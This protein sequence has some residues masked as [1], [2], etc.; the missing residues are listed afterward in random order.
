MIWFYLWIIATAIAIICGACIGWSILERIGCA[1]GIGFLVCICGVLI[2]YGLNVICYSPSDEFKL[3]ETQ[4]LYSLKDNTYL[5][6][7]GGLISVRIEEEDKYTYMVVNE[8]G[9]FSK[10]TIESDNVKI[11]EV[12]GCKEPIL[13]V[14][15][16]EAK[17]E[18]WSAYW[19][20]HYCFVV[21][22][23]TVVNTFNI[24]LE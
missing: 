10:K 13:E 19:E 15:K 18:F 16:C 12:D 17:N 2:A 22:K 4:K 7:Y 21:P 24:D 14:Y 5:S 20:D 3:E 9:T 1:I 6:G 8:D 23:G 11:K